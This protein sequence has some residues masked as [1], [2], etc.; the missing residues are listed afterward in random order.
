MIPA[1]IA[2]GPRLVMRQPGEY[3]EIPLIRLE[4]LENR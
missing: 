3:E 2:I 4:R 1:P